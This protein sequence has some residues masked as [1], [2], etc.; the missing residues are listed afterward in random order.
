MKKY[1]FLI[2]SLTLLINSY[3]ADKQKV[4]SLINIVNNTSNDTVKIA[5]IFAWDEEIYL[6]FPDSSIILNSLVVEIAEQQLLSS[7]TLHTTTVYALKKQKASALNNLGSTYNQLG[8]ITKAIECHEESLLIKQE[9]GYKKGIAYSYNNLGYIY[10]NQANIT[11]ALECYHKSLKIREEIGDKKEIAGSMI[12]LGIVYYHQDNTEQALEYFYNSS[13]LLEEVGDKKRI[14][15]TYINI[16][17]IY[18]NQGKTDEALEFFDKSLK[19]YKKAGNLSGMADVYNNLGSVY[20]KENKINQAIEYFTQSISLYK[21]IDRKQGL[22]RSYTNIANC[23]VEQKKYS[24]AIQYS[25]AALSL[26]QETRL[27]LEIRDAAKVLFENYKLTGNNH[28]ALKMYQ[29]FIETRDSILSTENQKESIRQKFKYEYEKQAAADSIYAAEAKKVTDAQIAAQKAQ[30]SQEKTQRIALYGG[31]ALLIIFG[32][33]MYNR[34]RI[35][36][37]QNVIIELQKNEVEEKNKEILDSINYAKRIQSAILPSSQLV[38]N[39]LNESFILY[40]PKDIVAGDFYWIEKRGDSVLFAAADCTGHGV[41]GAMVSVVCNNGLNRAVREHGLR[42]PGEILDKT[43]EIVVQE[44]EKSDEEVQDG[45]DIALCSITE[46]KL[47]YAGA[48][49]PLWIIR[50]GK[51]LETKANKQPIGKFDLPKPYTTHNIDLL[52]EDAIYIFSDG[53]ADQFGGEKGKK[54]KAKAFKKLLLSIQHLSM[55][56]QKTFINEAFKNWKGDLDQLDDVCVIGLKFN[57]K[58]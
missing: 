57:P 20:Y 56:E 11:M 47:Q 6:H 7:R 49:N 46:N 48:H 54:L 25:K 17:H 19:I 37:K 12:N 16:G 42:I 29:L 5:A 43:R 30:I 32:A 51:I 22:S 45:M 3:S 15:Y 21:K 13:R 44:F 23:Y 53:Y 9:I 58:L 14:A 35:T 2:F 31:L 39:H 24:K 41:P 52:S 27:T 28:E 55:N 34:F 33:F 26:A 1:L 8:N 38:K 40:L 50:D 18:S 4:D 10:S 36:K